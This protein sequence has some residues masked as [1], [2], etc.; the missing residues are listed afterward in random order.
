MYCS[1]ALGRRTRLK[2]KS[3]PYTY[4]LLRKLFDAGGIKVTENDSFKSRNVDVK[5]QGT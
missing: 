5:Q 3:V 4:V 1:R 2:I